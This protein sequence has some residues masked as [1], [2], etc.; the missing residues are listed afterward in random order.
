MI[1]C[2][3][4]GSLTVFL[5]F[6][7]LWT[8]GAC[9]SIQLHS[10]VWNLRKPAL[11]SRFSNKSFQSICFSSFLIL[12]SLLLSKFHVYITLHSLSDLFWFLNSIR[13]GK[14]SLMSS[15][16]R[17]GS[18]SI[19]SFGLV[20]TLSIRVAV[21]FVILVG[22]E[23]QGFRS[24]SMFFSRNWLVCVWRWDFKRSRLWSIPTIISWCLS[25]FRFVSKVVY[26]LMNTLALALGGL[27]PNTSSIF[28]VSVFNSM[29]ICSKWS[30]STCKSVLTLLYRFLFIRIPTPP[31]NLSF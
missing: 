11:A 2:V 1:P 12:S 20:I 3:I 6:T 31:P 18:I 24:R 19:W 14:W 16:I 9:L 17:W 22:L 29:T 15:I 21:L 13:I 26:S 8:S 5:W 23:M 4:H 7:F 30:V 28:F 10:I 25:L 27:Y